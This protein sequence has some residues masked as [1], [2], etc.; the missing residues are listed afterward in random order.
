MCLLRLGVTKQYKLKSYKLRTDGRLVKVTVLTLKL[1]GPAAGVEGSLTVTIALKPLWSGMGEIVPAC[2]S[3][4][5]H[6]P[7]PSH[8]A[9]IALFESVSVHQLS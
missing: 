8:C 3:P 1:P 9:V 6:P 2:T 4:T 7:I 5:L